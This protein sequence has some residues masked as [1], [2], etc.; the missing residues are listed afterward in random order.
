MSKYILTIEGNFEKG[1]CYSCP[2]AFNAEDI[3]GDS[4]SLCSQ[5]VS[6][7]DCPLEEVKQ[8]DALDILDKWQFLLG[9]RAGRD[10]WS[11]KPTE[12]QNQDIAD[13]NRDIEI[14]RKAVSDEGNI[15]QRER[16]QR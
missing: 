6:Y 2:L 11:D 5:M 7:E 9:Q 10:L 1:D 14:V 15:I 16:H 3:Y 13:F 8:G 4:V 12:V